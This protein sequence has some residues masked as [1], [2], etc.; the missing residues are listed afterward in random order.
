MLFS[1]CFNTDLRIRSWNL[2]QSYCIHLQS[3][4]HIRWLGI[5][6]HINTDSMV[7]DW[8]I[9]CRIWASNTYNRLQLAVCLYMYK[10]WIGRPGLTDARCICLLHCFQPLK[11]TSTTVLKWLHMYG[12]SSIVLVCTMLDTGQYWRGWY[13]SLKVQYPTQLHGY[14]YLVCTSRLC[15]FVF[16][17]VQ[18]YKICNYFRMM[19]QVLYSHLMDRLWLHP[20]CQLILY[21]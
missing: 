12:A 13:R 3:Y 8:D 2:Y 11:C 9:T 17:K 16:S 1:N 5:F 20:P 18:G 19:P 4:S 6:H 7:P 21:S 15:I 10:H 14:T